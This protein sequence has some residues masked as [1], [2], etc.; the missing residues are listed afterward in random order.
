MISEFLTSINVFF[1]T[2]NKES[3]CGGYQKE[4]SRL[5]HLLFYFVRHKK[6]RIHVSFF[7]TCSI[8]FFFILKCAHDTRR[9]DELLYFVKCLKIYV[10]TTQYLKF[11]EELF[12]FQ[13]SIRESNSLI[14]SWNY[15]FLLIIFV[16][17]EMRTCTNTFFFTKM[18]DYYCF[19]LLFFLRH[20]IVH[21]SYEEDDDK[22]ST[23]PAVFHSC[24]AM[25]PP[26]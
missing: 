14:I 21:E 26:F 11:R 9:N 10:T 20:A 6:I 17:H 22:Y 2:R 19:S 25:C 4:F 15:I 5:Y 24:H 13:F 12:S 3:G 16:F 8:W 1:F 23:M 7:C 18:K